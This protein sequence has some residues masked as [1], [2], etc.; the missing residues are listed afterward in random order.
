MKLVEI[1]WHP[2]T[3]QLRQFGV[4]CLVAVPAA[5]WL[6]GC[7]LQIVA[8]IA[9][10]GLVLVGTAMIVP[11]TL[12][13]IYVAFSMVAMPLGMVIGELA[14]L[15]IYFGVFLPIGLVFRIIGRDVL[16]MRQTKKSGTYWQPKKRPTSIGKYYR[17]S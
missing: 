1:N 6:W 8:F 3:R 2:N 7:S 16:D 15:F 14:M 4:I 9:L 13:P 5:A 10:A 11:N 17:Q 12:K